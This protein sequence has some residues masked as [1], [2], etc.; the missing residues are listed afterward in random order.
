MFQGTRFG[1]ISEIDLEM[2]GTNPNKIRQD[3]TGTKF[4]LPLTA[5]PY[6]NAQQQDG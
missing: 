6:H 5:R 1:V 3:V 4:H 2:A